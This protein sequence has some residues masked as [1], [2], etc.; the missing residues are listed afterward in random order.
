[1]GLGKSFQTV[2]LLWLFFQK[3][4]VAVQGAAAC[5]AIAAGSRLRLQEGHQHL[6]AAP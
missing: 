5:S 4:W 3:R 1:M 2:A 6:H